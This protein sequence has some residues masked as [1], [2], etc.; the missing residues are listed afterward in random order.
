MLGK[1]Y[2]S[3]VVMLLSCLKTLQGHQELSDFL[4]V[5]SGEAQGLSDLQMIL[6]SS[7][8]RNSSLVVQSLSGSRRQALANTGSPSS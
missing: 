7:S 8:L 2:L 5:W 3:G 6:A 1:G 4:T